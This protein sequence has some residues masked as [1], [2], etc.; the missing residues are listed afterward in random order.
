MVMAMF[1]PV[2]RSWWRK[3]SMRGVKSPAIIIIV[4]IFETECAV[5]AAPEKVMR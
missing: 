3:I 2:V 1:I 4:R 5:D